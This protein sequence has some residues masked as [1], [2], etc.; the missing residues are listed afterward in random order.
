MKRFRRILVYVGLGRNCA[1]MLLRAAD[2][3]TM[4][5]AELTVVSCYEKPP[6]HALSVFSSQEKPERLVRAV[7]ETKTHLLEQTVRPFEAVDLKV[8]KK[9]LAGP[10]FVAV[11][12][13]VLAHNHDLV[14]TAVEDQGF[15]AN[16]FRGSTVTHLLRKCPCPVWVFCTERKAAGHH[17]VAAIDA[18]AE[19]PEEIE[20]NATIL[21]LAAS[22]ASIEKAGLTTLY[23]WE[24][25]GEEHLLV[26]PTFDEKQLRDYVLD[27]RR[28][29]QAAYRRSVDAIA[30]QFPEVEIRRH[31]LKGDPGA[32]I[33]AFLHKH[34]T[35]VLVMGT[36][37][38]TGVAGFF[39]GN[40]AEKVLHSI[41]CSLLA[42]KPAG[43]V[44]P[45][46]PPTKGTEKP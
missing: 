16:A 24:A 30:A 35:T 18:S 44:S 10:A 40:T 33:P 34:R 14:M 19:E 37:A 23:C 39:I 32:L 21:Q 25:N 12:Q 3:A 4:N 1:A 46:H 43:Y 11:I 38:R 29:H 15:A 9:L 17:I 13:E 5:Q 8:K 42:V 36:V 41:H 2:L 27:F 45:V 6:A 28:L 26:D 7:V 31:M 22:L 20:M